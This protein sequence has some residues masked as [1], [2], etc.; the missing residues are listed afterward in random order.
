MQNFTCGNPN[1]C[2]GCTCSDFSWWNSQHSMNQT[3]IWEENN[4]DESFCLFG[5]K[6][7]RVVF[8]SFL[9]LKHSW[10]QR[11]Q[12]FLWGHLKAI[13]VLLPPSFRRNWGDGGE[14]AVI[15]EI[16]LELG[17]GAGKPCVWTKD[18]RVARLVRI[19]SPGVAGSTAWSPRPW[20][21]PD[22]RRLSCGQTPQGEPRPEHVLLGSSRSGSSEVSMDLLELEVCVTYQGRPQVRHEQC[23][24]RFHIWPVELAVGKCPCPHRQPNS[25]S[26]EF[27][28]NAAEHL[29]LSLPVLPEP[30]S[31]S[32]FC[33]TSWAG[34]VHSQACAGDERKGHLLPASTH[35]LSQHPGTHHITQLFPWTKIWPTILFQMMMKIREK[36]K[37]SFVLHT[38]LLVIK[39]LCNLIAG[40]FADIDRLRYEA[41][42]TLII[43][44]LFNTVVSESSCWNIQN[45]FCK[46][47]LLFSNT[48]GTE[49]V[50]VRGIIRRVFL[51]F[52]TIVSSE[53]FLFSSRVTDSSFI[54]SS[55]KGNFRLC[56]KLH[57]YDLLFWVT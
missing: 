9:F 41:V 6:L 16:P 49:R 10:R 17:G 7:F 1:R 52:K 20:P 45:G 31:I 19:F 8:A 43:L 55:C 33:F 22:L 35:Y 14:L 32:R 4:R 50:R 38:G 47:K 11:Q 34:S 23:R 29:L 13:S 48:V 51:L 28:W 24:G 46:I 25:I 27:Q 53:I 2:L 21:Y 12:L 40:N 37:K 15:Q 39:W 30:F 57:F 54:K 3:F 5:F 26:W 44:F 18:S 36:E 42:L 56:N